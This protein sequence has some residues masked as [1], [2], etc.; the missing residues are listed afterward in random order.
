MKLKILFLICLV[1]ISFLFSTYG[2]CDRIKPYINKRTDDSN[3]L[4]GLNDTE[5]KNN[6]HN[7]T[8]S[9]GSSLPHPNLKKI[10]SKRLQ[11]KTKANA[12]TSTK[13]V[14]SFST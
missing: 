3:V 14:Y 7:S 12:S 2:N 6:A 10:L 4:E 8:L 5:I 1:I 9:A 13:N 11:K